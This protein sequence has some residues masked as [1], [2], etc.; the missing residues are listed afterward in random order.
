MTKGAI[1]K[2]TKL[3]TIARQKLACRGF[4]IKK[5][6]TIQFTQLIL[7]ACLGLI[8]VGSVTAQ[9]LFVAVGQNTVGSSSLYIYNTANGTATIF[10]SGLNSSQGLA[11]DN[12][13]NLYVSDPAGGNIFRITPGGVQS[14]FASG[15]NLPM[16]LAFDSTGNLF[17]A[18][19]GSGNIY[20][21]TPGGTRSTF[22]SGLAIPSAVAIDSSGNVYVGD[23][24]YIYEYSPG[25]TQSTFV[26][27]L[28]QPNPGGIR[29]R[30]AFD[31][32]GDLFVADLLG[33]KVYKFPFIAP[34]LSPNS[35]VFASGLAT[36]SGLA[37]DN[38]GNLFVATRG[39]GTVYEYT[40]S[41]VQSVF[42]S[43]LNGNPTGLAMQPGSGT[44]PPS[45]QSLFVANV[46]SGTI[47]VYSTFNG[48]KSIFAS[49]LNGPV[50]LTFD[51]AGNLFVGCNGDHSIYKFSPGGV[52]TTFATG[53]T[54]PSGLACDGAGN[55]FVADQNSG[56]IYK[57][58]QGG[59]QSIFYSGLNLPSALA[60]DRAGDLFV[61]TGDRSIY[62][63]QNVIGTLSIPP[64]PFA[65]NIG[66]VNPN[67]NRY[68]MAFNNA[69]TLFVGDPPLNAIYEFTP[70]G[71]ESTF[72]TLVS[73][74]TGLAFDSAGNLFE[75]DYGSGKIFEYPP[76]GGG[77]S[78]FAS[79]EYGSQIAFQPVIL[80]GPTTTGNLF[81]SFFPDG[82]G[83]SPYIAE[84]SPNGV[85]TLFDTGLHDPWALA[86][87][88]S[89]NLYVLDIDDNAI[90][91]YANVN[92]KL[93]SRSLFAS[94]PSSVWSTGLVCDSG[95]NVYVGDQ[96]S[97]DIYEYSPSGAFSTFYYGNGLGGSS[98]L[99]ID[100]MNNLFA[101]AG[102]AAGSPIYEFSPSRVVFG[103]VP[104]GPEVVWA[105]GCDNMDNVYAA[106]PSDI[107]W[108]SPVFRFMPGGVVS[109]IDTLNIPLGVACDDMNNAYVIDTSAQTS[110]PNLPNTSAVAI[111]KYSLGGARS[112]FYFQQGLGPD[113]PRSLAFQPAPSP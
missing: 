42:A 73:I 75:M 61:A 13:G 108:A 62:E 76:S 58:T 106:C 43:G 87:D 101:V 85:E 19:D 99:A 6:T 12:A 18:D 93:T 49:G 88:R 71:G 20:K 1:V 15:L 3:R 14:T 17:E 77:S 60:I 97:G 79:G 28:G 102:G 47:D 8:L 86:F 59:T 113:F 38:S 82:P 63:F 2:S 84:F 105:I 31:G 24:G 65:S 46:T 56:N 57:Y 36:P 29:Y 54:F 39:N 89:G 109:Q 55:L 37:C 100:F 34:S 23:N 92:G 26:S 72:T 104:M 70:S 111:Y 10:A 74:P 25:G 96:F 90:Y 83:Q 110:P 21:F 98:G 103:I 44:T 30:F 45:A 64:I 67:G 41:G 22:A 95:G 78:V 32:V 80:H 16:G 112:F 94:V 5:Q 35:Q 4:Q 48:T 33:G 68:R 7:I 66:P 27:G 40:P 53:L 91:K 51:G 107:P 9:N 50:A 81:V 11:F 52:K 69:G